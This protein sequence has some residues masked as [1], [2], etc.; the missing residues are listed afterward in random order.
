MS[1]DIEEFGKQE[2]ERVLSGAKTIE[3]DILYVAKRIAFHERELIIH[4]SNF[5]RLL[6]TLKSE[7]RDLPK[8]EEPAAERPVEI[9]E[10]QQVEGDR[11][12][13]IDAILSALDS[14]G[15]M[16]VEELQL[17]FDRAGSVPSLKTIRQALRSLRAQRRCWKPTASTYDTTSPTKLD[18]VRYQVVRQRVLAVLKKQTPAGAHWISESLDLPRSYVDRVLLLLARNGEALF[19]GE[20]GYWSF[21]EKKQKT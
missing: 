16:S 6:E 11:T 8:A 10:A 3:D 4:R 21:L 12:L 20:T 19:N 13:V 1:D 15:P 2:G 7:A 17:E 9:E 5:R 14:G 18:N